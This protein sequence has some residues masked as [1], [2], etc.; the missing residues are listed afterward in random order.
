MT[1]HAGCASLHALGLKAGDDLVGHPDAALRRG[2]RRRRVPLGDRLRGAEQRRPPASGKNFLVVLNDNKMSI[3]PRVG[4]VGVLPRQGAHGCPAST[5]DWN[6]RTIRDLL[7]SIPLV[8]DQADQA[9]SS[10]SRTPSRRSLH[11]GMLFEELGFAYIGP[12]DGHDL[13][14]AAQLPP[15]R[16]RRWTGP[17]LLHVLTEK[18]HGFPPAWMTR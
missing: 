16:S 14:D 8:G 10:S 13:Q 4:G 12:I 2:H 17:V 15:R 6:K 9:G 3:C 5:N 18:G 1:G 11:G 7:P